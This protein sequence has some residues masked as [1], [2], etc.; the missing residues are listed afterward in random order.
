MSKLYIVT[1]ST[2]EW[3]DRSTW[4]VRAF[5]DKLVAQEFV[6]TLTCMYEQYQGNKCGYERPKQEMV[7]LEEQL[8]QFDPEFCED[9]TGTHWYI[10]EVAYGKT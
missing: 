2:G 8:W 3:S 7:T 1:G 6:N 9:Y 4:L 5:E 10:E